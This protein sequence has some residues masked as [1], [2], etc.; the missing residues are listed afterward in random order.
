MLKLKKKSL[1]FFWSHTLLVSVFFLIPAGIQPR[2]EEETGGDVGSVDFR[3]GQTDNR[4][5]TQACVYTQLHR[6]VTPYSC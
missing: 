6:A 5:D 2:V 4:A 1:F 3:F